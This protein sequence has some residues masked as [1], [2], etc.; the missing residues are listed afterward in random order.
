MPLKQKKLKEAA[1]N[2]NLELIVEE[3]NNELTSVENTNLNNDK[4]P[5]YNEV[6]VN[7]ETENS[8]LNGDLNE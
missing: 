7:I 4:I 3:K 8:G 1:L 5:N 2:Q 6:N